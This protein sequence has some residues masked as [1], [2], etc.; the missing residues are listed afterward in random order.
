MKELVPADVQY[1]PG[2]IS[3]VV[4]RFVLQKLLC[5]LKTSAVKYMVVYIEYKLTYALSMHS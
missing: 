3:L 2:E 1:L 5:C 4:C